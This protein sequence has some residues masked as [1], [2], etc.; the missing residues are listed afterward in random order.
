ML[1]QLFKKYFSEN[2][3]VRR[4]TGLLSIDILQKASN[5]LLL[6]FFL[7]FMSQ[8][9]YG[10]YGY[11]VAIVTVLSSHLIFSLHHAQGKLYYEYSGERRGRLLFTASSMTGLVLLVVLVPLYVF[12]FDDELIKLMIRNEFDY[13]KYRWLI[14][15]AIFYA[16]FSMLL[17]NFMLISERIKLFQAYNSVRLLL[18]NP[19]SLVLLWL[20]TYDS[21]W[22]RFT[23]SYG[24][25]L[26]LL[27][28]FGIPYLKQM[29]FSWDKEIAQ[30]LKDICS[31]FIVGSIASLLFQ[32]SDRFVL[33]KYR[34]L[35]D[36]GTYNL[37]ITI[38]SVIYMLNTSVV[39]AY[40]PS[41]FKE[42]NLKVN[43]QKTTRVAFRLFL[44]YLGLGFLLFSLTWALLYFNIIN[45][46]YYDVLKL[47]PILIIAQIAQS[48]ILMYGYFFLFIERT[49]FGVKI[50]VVGSVMS[51]ILYIATVPA[52]GYYGIAFSML[53]TA[54]SMLLANV[55]Y[56]QKFILNHHE[57]KRQ[58]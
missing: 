8:E 54:V 39:N 1:K 50:T 38:A 55:W 4:T 20:I 52:F 10:L 9:E 22:V 44:A 46:S 45:N 27:I 17:N 34:G 15:P 36:M 41:F 57:Y 37:A 12:G 56:A 58:N 28:L 25:E 19:G 18:V 47:L 11:L 13:D 31:P 16:A 51:L 48:L 6:P 40:L 2:Q 49:R 53:I 30:R 21:V 26:L 32:L 3:L 33:D 5:F 29:S 43:Y 35:S 7:R 42:Q 24:W 23:W 14:L